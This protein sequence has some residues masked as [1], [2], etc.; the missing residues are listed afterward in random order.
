MDMFRLRATDP[1]PCNICGKIYKNAHTLRTHME[2]KHSQCAGFRCV[3]CGTVAKSRNSL[4]SHMSRQHRG[5]STRD[6]PLL[7]MPAPWDPELAARFIARSGGRGEVVR[8]SVSRWEKSVSSSPVPSPVSAGAQENGGGAEADPYRVNLMHQLAAQAVTSA[9]GGGAPAG[10]NG[11]GAPA[12]GAGAPAAPGSTGS[13]VL[14][15]YLQMMAEQGL[16]L[17]VGVTGARRP[18]PGAAPA[19][20]SDDEEEPDEAEE[21]DD[22]DK[23]GSD[24]SDEPD[25]GDKENVS[26]SGGTSDRDGSD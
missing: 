2:D 13:A 19:A 17:S 10:A 22:A 12:A 11:G 24:R 15:T 25:N 6:L 9:A 18:L 3:L 5:I 26:C 4:H 16:D 20:G 7:P 8:Q 21:A 14:D 1:R 23:D